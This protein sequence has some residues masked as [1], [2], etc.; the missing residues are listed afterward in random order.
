MSF[1]RILYLFAQYLTQYVIAKNEHQWPWRKNFGTRQELAS[2][3]LI[4]N[5]EMPGYVINQ[6]WFIEYTIRAF[7]EPTNILN[8]QQAQC[9]EKEEMTNSVGVIGSISVS[10]KTS[11]II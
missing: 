10:I 3:T 1:L 6:H 4:P 11:Y 8:N 9:N 2:E 5:S 7:F